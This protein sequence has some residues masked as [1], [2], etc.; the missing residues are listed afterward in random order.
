MIFQLRI[1]QRAI[2]DLQRYLTH[3]IAETRRLQ[4]ALA[5]VSGNFNHRQLALLQH[6]IKNPHAQYTVSSHAGS[7]N[8]VPQTARMDLHGLERR[9][10]LHKVALKRAHAW[11]PAADLM[12]L[13]EPVQGS[14]GRHRLTRS[15]D[16][17]ATSTPLTPARAAYGT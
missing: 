7:H 8:V 9:G 4:E 15:G 17:G 11:I 1:I 12:D 6:A 13:L 2:T 10:L 14:V 5:A 16:R 3:K